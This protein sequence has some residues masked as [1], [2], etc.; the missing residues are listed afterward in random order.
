LFD[1]EILEVM[2]PFL[3]FITGLGI[4]RS[5]GKIDIKSLFDMMIKL[6]KIDDPE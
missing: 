3:I 5:H 1:E 6:N 4:G 2:D